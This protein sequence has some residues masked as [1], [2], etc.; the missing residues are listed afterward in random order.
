VE[1]LPGSIPGTL[2]GDC[3]GLEGFLSEPAWEA[4]LPLG[5]FEAFDIVVS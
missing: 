1:L 2:P 3:D 4:G 5:L